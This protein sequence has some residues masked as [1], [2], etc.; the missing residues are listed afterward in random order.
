[1]KIAFALIATVTLGMGCGLTDEVVQDEV[2]QDE[3]VQVDD[4]Q[5][6]DQQDVTEES[7]DLQIAEVE[8]EG[9]TVLQ[10][11]ASEGGGVSVL[12]RGNISSGRIAVTKESG[13]EDAS[14]KDIFWAVTGPGTEIPV[15]LEDHHRYLLAE[16]KIP[17]GD[18]KRAQGWLLEQRKD[19]APKAISDCVNAVFWDNHCT[20]ASGQYPQQKCFLNRSG[21]TTWISD[22]ADR[23]K[24]GI[25]VQE[26]QVHDLLTYTT[27]NPYGACGFGFPGGTAINTDVF[28]GGYL[29]WIWW[30]GS[31]DWWRTWTH[32]VTEGSSSDVYDHGQRWRY[33]PSCL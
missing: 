24:A 22:R 6:S 30:A 23:Y 19:A 18:T 31:G 14:P 26:G 2:V 25:C 9:G 13:L 1:M 5:D 4:L 17:D 28:T 16:G 8:V 12:E 33:R 10:F 21:N 7:F 27:H 11:F 32:K 15:E 20:S 3:V 29:V